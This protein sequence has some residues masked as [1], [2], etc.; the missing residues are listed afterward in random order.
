MV[1]WV[2]FEKE[3]K[4]N[5]KFKVNIVDVSIIDSDSKLICETG[6]YRGVDIA[7]GLN[8]LFLRWWYL[9]GEIIIICPFISG[10]G[11]SYFDQIGNKIFKT[12][13]KRKAKGQT[14]IYQLSE[15]FYV[16]KFP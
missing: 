12:H 4:G 8:D 6:L 1:S 13:N 14:F 15:S 16:F 9:N 3:D 11:I 10:D 2:E 7:V 5:N